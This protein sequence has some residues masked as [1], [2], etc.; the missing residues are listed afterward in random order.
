MITSTRNLKIQMIRALNAHAKTRRE[1]GAFV[2]EGVRLVEESLARGWLPEL[3]FFSESISERGIQLLHSYQEQGIQVEQVAPHV[4]KAASDTETPQG[5][6]A[7]LP[8]KHLPLPSE[9]GFILIL[10]GIR[11]PGNVGAILR[12][13]AA[14]GVEALLLAP[15]SADPFAPKVLRSGMGAHFRLPI[16]PMAWRE[17]KAY[18][19]TVASRMDLKI[20]LADPEGDTIYSDTDMKSPLALIIGGEAEGTGEQAQSIAHERIKIPMPGKVESLN[21]AV[22][23]GIL[24]YEAVRQ[25]IS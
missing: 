9:P 25:R 11:D 12:T 16:S 5:I 10:D 14:A 4:L 7:V 17:L 15:G 22:A 13:A 2:V 3:V 24:M 18:L 23:A 19:R 1:Q 6:L 8:L 20:Y 21:A